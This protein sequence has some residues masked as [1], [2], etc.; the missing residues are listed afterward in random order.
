MDAAAK[1]IAKIPPKRN[2]L[3]AKAIISKTKAIIVHKI[4]RGKFVWTK[5]VFL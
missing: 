4:V 3:S 1:R 5:M 2:W